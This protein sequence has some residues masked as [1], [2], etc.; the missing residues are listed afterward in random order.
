MV[1]TAY[2]CDDFKLTESGTLEIFGN[3]AEFKSNDREIVE[4]FI[5]NSIHDAVVCPSIFTNEFGV[6]PKK[7][8][9]K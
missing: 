8:I 7:I 1:F 6:P 2:V 5:N 3:H 4:Q 9:F